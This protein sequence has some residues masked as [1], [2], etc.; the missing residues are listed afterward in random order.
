MVYLITHGSRRPAG[1]SNLSSADRK[2][3][4]GGSMMQEA[5]IDDAKQL[6]VKL[7]LNKDLVWQIIKGKHYNNLTEMA[8]AIQRAFA[9]TPLP[10]P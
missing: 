2:V 5:T 9:A 1:F 6:S 8:M 10:R 4:Q 7:N 3:I